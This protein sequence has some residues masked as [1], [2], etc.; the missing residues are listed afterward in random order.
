MF[1]VLKE[2]SGF[3]YPI[4]A[5]K[6]GGNPRNLLSTQENAAFQLWILNCIGKSFS[7][8]REIIISSSNCFYVKLCN[9]DL[10]REKITCRAH[11]I[12]R[13]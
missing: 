7:E 6:G 9:Q 5:V 8:C 3:V 4:C 11:N 1:A 13:H 10:W 12:R 2:L